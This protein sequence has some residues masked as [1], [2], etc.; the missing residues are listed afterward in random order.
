MVISEILNVRS[1]A[2]HD[3]GLI[4]LDLLTKALSSGKKVE[5]SFA[6]LRQSGSQFIHTAIG[7]LYLRFSA[8]VVESL[9]SYDYAD[10]PNLQNKISEAKWSAIN[11]KEYEQ[12]VENAIS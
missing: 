4:I 12:L 2:Y 7:S 8:D 1:V 11:S 10:V 9:L 6:G 3:E 5:L